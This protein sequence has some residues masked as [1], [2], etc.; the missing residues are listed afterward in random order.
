MELFI[1]VALRLKETGCFDE[2]T[3]YQSLMD[4]AEL[5]SFFVRKFP[6]ALSYLFNVED[7]RAATWTI[8]SS[9]STGI[10]GSLKKAYIQWYKNAL[11]TPIQKRNQRLRHQR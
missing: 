6:E 10:I 8:S 9:I 5:W 7:D 2:R 11:L 1:E 4:E 3:G